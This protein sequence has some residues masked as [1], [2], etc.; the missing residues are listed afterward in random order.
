M[1]ENALKFAEEYTDISTDH[2][3]IIKHAWKSFLFNKS[4]IWMK[5]DSVLFDVAIGAFDGAKVC[6]HVSNFLLYNLSE[7][8][9]RKNL[10]LH[11]DDGL[12]IIK[13]VNGPFL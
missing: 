5:K 1:L 11:R 9:K 7:K 4:E 6:E 10:A 3:A 12:A 2:K 8:C 13:N